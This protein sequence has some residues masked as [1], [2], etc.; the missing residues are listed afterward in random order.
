MLH[1]PTALPDHHYLL[2]C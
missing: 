2:N 1:N